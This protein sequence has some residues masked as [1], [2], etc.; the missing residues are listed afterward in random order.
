MASPSTTRPDGAAYWASFVSALRARPG[1][2][3]SPPASEAECYASFVRLLR[4]RREAL[5]LSQAELDEIIGLC[6]GHVQKWERMVRRPTGFN[7]A[8]WVAALGLE[9]WARQP[10]QGDSNV[11]AAHERASLPSRRSA[12]RAA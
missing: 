12:R 2:L 3:P 5:G 11:G 4:A 6:G 10:V 7:L 1:Q 9:L 8:N